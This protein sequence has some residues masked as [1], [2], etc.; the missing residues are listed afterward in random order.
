[1]ILAGSALP[2][3]LYRADQT[4]E[5]DR[6]ATEEHGIP[7]I[8]LM[9][10][11]GRAAFGLL[12]VLWPQAGEIG[13][14]CGN[15]NNG[16]DGLVLARL[17]RE[18]RRR[19]RVL[20]PE[21]E[22][23]LRGEAAVAERRLREAGGTVAA[24]E[25]AGLDGCEVLVDGVL[26]TGLTR[27]VTGAAARA[28]TALNASDAPVLA[29]DIP[30]GLHADSG[31]ALGRAVRADAT[32]AFVALKRGL[33]TGDG[34][35]YGGRLFHTGLGVPGEAS[36]TLGPAVGRLELA[37]L[38]HLLPPRPR[39]A[40]KGHFGHVLIVGGERGF[41]GAVCMAAEAA[42]RCGAGLVSVAARTGHG[43]YRPETMVHPVERAEELSPLLERASVLA[44]GPGLGRADWGRALLERALDSGLP[45]VVDADALNLLAERPQRSE[46]WILTPHP[47]EAARLLGASTAAVQADR[48]AAAAELQ[49]RYGGV[50]VLKGAGTLIADTKGTALCPAGNPGMASG[51]M[52]DVLT[53]TIAG[54]Q[55]Q[56]LDPQA[57]ARLGVCLHAAAGDAAANTGGERGLLARDLMPW[58]HRLS[59]P[60]SAG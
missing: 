35:E 42:A 40:H 17:A 1:M 11:A 55:A 34:P 19:V 7:G 46:R 6:L 30:S 37:D 22:R 18:A 28:V 24:L 2:R 56:G 33:L 47:G 9:E 51:G 10:R 32:V 52:G 60:P 15:G 57:A 4:R 5:L 59:N 38:E 23:A 36:E 31:A 53:G 29:L 25:P 14:V 49:A 48:F 54:L 26:G 20:R 50:A 3:A 27:P 45:A 44:V 39:H 21:P 41:T 58:L 12:N 13:V 8:V 43:P 16:G